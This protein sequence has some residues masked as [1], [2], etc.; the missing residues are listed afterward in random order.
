MENR[1]L[2]KEVP[3]FLK[4]LCILSIIGG[5]FSIIGSIISIVFLGNPD[6]I[7]AIADIFEQSGQD[8]P[9]V[10]SQGLQNGKAIGIVTAILSLLSITGAI[11]ML[12]LKKIGFFMYLIATISVMFVQPLFNGFDLFTVGGLVLTIIWNTLWIVSY[13]VHLKYMK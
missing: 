13:G 4:V 9:E 2:E 6:V 10:F 12:N 3:S 7:S 5:S 8:M 11:F 1:M